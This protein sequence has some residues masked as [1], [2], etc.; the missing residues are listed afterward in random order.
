MSVPQGLKR[1]VLIGFSATGKSVL[2][3]FIA[4]RL[5]WDSIDLDEEV[6][7]AAGRSIPEIFQSEGERGFRVRE[8]QAV[9]EAVARE[10]VVIATGGGAW[11]HAE[12]R[13]LL[14]EQG[15]VI[16]L[17]AR[18]GTIEA[19]Y[20]AAAEDSAEQR[21]MLSGA[22]RL[23]RIETLKA[24]RQ[25]FYALSD[26]TVHTD[27]HVDDAVDFIIEAVQRRGGAVLDSE[28]RLREMRNGPGVDPPPI[29]DYG[30]DV[31]C[32][33]ETE[34]AQY[35]VYCAW[36]LLER[37]GDVLDRLGLTGRV[38]MI[39]DEAVF[40][41]HGSTALESLEQS[42]R[43]VNSY[44][45]PSGEASKSLASLELLYEWL[46]SHR[47]ERRDVIFA[48][49]GGMNHRLGRHGRSH[50][51]ARHAAGPCADD[52]ARHG[53][54]RNRREGCRRPALGQEPGRGVLPNLA[55]WWPTSPR[56]RRSRRGNCAPASPR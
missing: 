34:S 9:Q 37:S 23:R 22:G 8:Q 10:K 36:G 13:A 54:R 53:R 4:D 42:G 47:A 41:T 29:H 1:I 20:A 44:R 19:R 40:D 7:Q 55:R 3:P 16:T 35:P 6:E 51:P 2:A 17:E 24:A 27:D 31:G 30:P 39:V 32:I 45:V 26:L 38:F 25:P 14:A 11:L 48:L 21:P 52:G 56:W 18:S 33:V 43:T 50:L 49:G 28:N 46:S 5:G 15:F 12:N